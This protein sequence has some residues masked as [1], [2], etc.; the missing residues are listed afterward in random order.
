M[1]I[2]E[3]SGKPEARESSP[4][5]FSLGCSRASRG[6]GLSLALFFEL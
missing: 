5:R 3:K 6:S 1:W 2:G 4:L